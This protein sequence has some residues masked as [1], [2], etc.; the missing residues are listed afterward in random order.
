MHAPNQGLT[1]QDDLKNHLNLWKDTLIQA[2]R[3]DAPD[4][5]NRQMALM[6]IVYLEDGPH[7]VRFLAERLGVSK[8]VISRALDH[9][10]QLGLLKRKR[11]ES[12]KR[13]L[14]VQ[15][16]DK[17]AVYLSEFAKYIAKSTQ[18]H[19]QRP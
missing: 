10:G 8:P 3:T 14:F 15:K 16:T 18:R 2:V 17:G 1:M 5:N 7:M 4:L 12:D 19:E 9:L 13:N 6:L 11:D